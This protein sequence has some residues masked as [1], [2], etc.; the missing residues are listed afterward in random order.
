[1]RALLIACL[2]LAP[3]VSLADVPVPTPK[4]TTEAEVPPPV[5][6]IPPAA[7]ISGCPEGQGTPAQMWE[8]VNRLISDDRVYSTGA[9]Y[10]GKLAGEMLLALHAVTREPTK[11]ATAIVVFAWNDGDQSWLTMSEKCAP[12]IILLKPSQIKAIQAVMRVEA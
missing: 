7:S 1:M 12:A 11:G 6:V 10:T 8:M 4:P 3:S 5:I 2:A 9:V